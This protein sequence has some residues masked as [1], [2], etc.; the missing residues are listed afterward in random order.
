MAGSDRPREAL[1]ASS[2][3]ARSANG[4]KG[5]ASQD[6]R[7]GWFF[8]CDAWSIFALLA[9]DRWAVSLLLTD[10]IHKC[11]QHGWAR[12]R[13]DPH[14]RHEALRIARKE[15]LAGLSPDQAVAVVRCWEG[16]EIPVRSVPDGTCWRLPD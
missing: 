2:I 9:V 1:L 3:R 14:A 12:D 13:A 10:A 8:D 11:D 4:K 5:V 15:P 16:S 6:R 7:I